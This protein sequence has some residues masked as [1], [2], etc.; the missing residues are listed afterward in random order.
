MTLIT[1]NLR[2]AYGMGITVRNVNEAL[3]LVLPLVRDQGVDQVSRGMTVREMH[4]PFM[5]VYKQPFENVLFDPVRDANP[6]FHF[7]ES[8]WILAGSQHAA[9]PKFFLNR[10]T[11]YSDDG[12]TFHGAYGYR[13]RH[14]PDIGNDPMY[15]STESEIDQ[16]AKVVHLL[17]DKPDTRQA[18]M[19]IWNPVRDLGAKTK[20]MPCNDMIMFKL[21]GGRL[22]MTV[23]NRS[24]DVIWGA[25]GANAV[26]FSVLQ[27]W[28]AARVGAN[29]G[30][31]TQV[32]DSMHVYHDNPLWKKFVA[33]D[34]QPS[35][36]VHNPYDDFDAEDPVLPLFASPEDALAAQEDAESLDAMAQQGPQI[37]ERAAMRASPYWKS[38]LG[39]GT[40]RPMMAAYVNYRNEAY[41]TALVA[42]S[43]I[44]RPDWRLAC[45]QWIMRRMENRNA[46]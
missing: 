42:C 46:A 24:N 37:F 27:E 45:S 41:S 7:F 19:S 38:T 30:Y 8:M 31:Y 25:Y 14:W 3:A 9:M 10:I 1:K 5:T 6:F 43:H 22:D 12:Q 44:Q 28:V 16:L 29:V 40:M 23:C 32:S 21:R 20:D 33:G 2:P 35:G 36:L 4:G 15:P 26:Q 18:V 34:Y 11:D 17:L 13:L 39:A